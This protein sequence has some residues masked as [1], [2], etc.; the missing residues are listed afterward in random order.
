VKLT[1]I[2]VKLVLTVAAILA[3]EAGARSYFEAASDAREFRQN[4]LGDG[5][6]HAAGVAQA[7]EYGFLTRDVKELLRAADMLRTP[8]DADLLYVAFYDENGDLLASRR[9]ATGAG[10][11]DV[12]ARAPPDRT[13]GTKQCITPEHSDGGHYLFC[14]SVA[15]S[16]AVLGDGGEGAS[17]G[18]AGAETALVVTARSYEGVQERMAAA[19][20]ETIV[21]SAA[22]FAALMLALLVLAR[23]IVKPIQKLAKATERVAGGDLETRVDLGRRRDEFGVLA[24][25]FNRMTG[26]LR[27]QR[28]QILSHSRDL[29]R[30]VAERTEELARANE[31]LRCEAAERRRAEAERERLLERLQAIMD[32]IPAYI[33]LKD[34]EGRYTAV[35]RAYHDMLPKGVDEPVG[36]RDRDLFPPRL[37][38]VFEAE[39]R[40]VLEDGRAVTKEKPI[41]LRDGRVVHVAMSLDP[42]RSS[43]GRVVGL[44]G[45]AVDISERKR[46]EEAT[47]R[48]NAKLG[49][50]ISGMDEGV[51]FADA[52][53]VIVEVNAFFCRFVKKPREAILGTRIEDCHSGTT[54][55]RLRGLI[56]QFRA[57]PGSGPFVIQRPLGQAEVMLRMQPIYRDGRY[58][59]VL[60]NVVD[61]TELV[62]ARQAVEAANARLQELATTDD[63]TGLWNRRHF[64]GVF[65]QEFQRVRRHGRDLA[66]AMFDLDHFKTV[67]D[68]YGHAFGDRVLV[69]VARAIL[70]E[71]RETDV[72]V[73]Y[74]GE[75]FIVLMP[76]T[77]SEE[78]VSAVERIRKRVAERYISDGKH[79]VQVTLS[80]G[81][82]AAEA[83]GTSTPE[84]LLRLADE[85]LY[86][87]KHAGRDCVRTWRQICADQ[88]EEV[89]SQ[90]KQVDDLQRRMARL[91]LRSKDAFVQESQGLVQA[92]EARDP[93][94][95][96]HSVNVTRYAV[97]I[98][99]TLGLD[100]EETARIRRAAVLH[101]IGKIGVPDAIL[102]KPGPLTAEE[103][104]IMEEH[105]LVGVRMLEQLN[106]LDREVALVRHHHERWDG[107]GYP[108][109]VLGEAIPRGAR[110]LAVADALDAVVSDRVYRG[111][112]TVMEA[113]RTLQDE[114]GRQFD[115]AVVDALVR[116]VVEVGRGLGA[117]DEVTCEDLMRSQETTPTPLWLASPDRV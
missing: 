43:D 25:T 19:Q 58:D 55:D 104:C 96:S 42:V 116:W 72:A 64:F 13:A 9:Y 110:V 30:K 5:H 117:Q 106:F 87:A 67:N 102:R 109:G 29:E 50:M 4:F 69:E 20:R 74:G 63:L 56:E 103:R 23:R 71:V 27:E 57:N 77:S 3:V 113:I 16:R 79:S 7:A 78:A 84:A 90:S 82:S 65:K 18:T 105:V 41:R 92:L 114:A 68:T 95:K 61:V 101:D 93:Y 28:D 115:P 81:V 80:A 6:V 8:E 36:L 88:K 73:R 15:V 75:E 99:E 32:N 21:V 76:S 24:D 48:E 49:A 33:F 44:V 35:N 89:V 31:G 26:Q 66:L 45:A 34:A 85:A 37:A 97:A 47:R 53:G 62:R 94:M 39:D 2:G 54:P 11:T 10:V 91:S 100:P 111:G 17:G 98:A 12:P 107:R 59:G 52:D 22:V 51:V 46:A 108:D 112:G 70:G 83:S 14:V 40:A 60:L 38:E 1:S 86:A